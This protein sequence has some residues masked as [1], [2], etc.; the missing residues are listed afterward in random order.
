MKLGIAVKQS[1]GRFPN[2]S[3]KKIDFATS[4]AISIRNKKELTSADCFPKPNRSSRRAQGQLLVLTDKM[5][6]DTMREHQLDVQATSWLSTIEVNRLLSISRLHMRRASISR[7]RARHEGIEIL[8]STTPER[9]GPWATNCAGI[10][11]RKSREAWWWSRFLSAI[12][13]K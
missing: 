13:P 7:A 8:R 6:Q 2:C 11:W 3:P 9:C 10:S 1:Y 5:T 12:G 4:S